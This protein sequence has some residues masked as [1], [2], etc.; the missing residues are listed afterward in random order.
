MGRSRRERWKRFRLGSAVVAWISS[1]SR[2][3]AVELSPSRL[4]TLSGEDSMRA[5][6]VIA[7]IATAVK[8]S[9]SHPFGFVERNWN[10]VNVSQLLAEFGLNPV[11]VLVEPLGNHGG[12]SGARLWRVSRGDQ[13]WCLRQW[14]QGSLDEVR[15]AWIH[16]LQ[17]TAHEAGCSFVPLPCSVVSNRSRGL[18]DEDAAQLGHFSP[19]AAAESSPPDRPFEA[20][21]PFPLTPSSDRTWKSVD[22]WLWELTRWVPGR[23]DFCERP[24]DRRLAAAVMAVATFHQAV[25]KQTLVANQ[26]AVAPS[27]E[28]RI[29]RLAGLTPQR[30]RRMATAI[31]HRY[32]A[33][34]A[35]LAHQVMQYAELRRDRDLAQLEGARLPVRLQ[36]CLGDVWHDHLLFSGDQVTGLVDFG[37]ARIDSVATDLARLLGSLVPDQPDRWQFARERYREIMPLGVDEERLLAAIDRV[38][39]LLAGANWVKWLFVEERRFHDVEG[40]VAK[41]LEQ[42]ALRLQRQT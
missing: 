36:P 25:A 22:G 21:R 10:P 41:R 13:V 26:P 27:I 7:S 34:L 8:H 1:Q 5:R 35:R 31:D 30:C 12:M 11:D 38:N 19:H 23:A 29:E 37:A 18:A 15:L 4:V 28:I 24:T 40:S 42:I 20:M 17:R 16:G 3:K 14:P 2:I 33:E 39:P 32:G 9:T 6:V